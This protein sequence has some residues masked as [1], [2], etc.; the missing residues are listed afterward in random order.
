MP[1]L[2]DKPFWAHVCTSVTSWL[3]F[4]TRL[5]VNKLVGSCHTGS[6]T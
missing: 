2:G 5:N 4:S 3:H 1:K 6:V